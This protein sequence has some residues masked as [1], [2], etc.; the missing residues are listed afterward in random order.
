MEITIGTRQES[1]LDDVYTAFGNRERMV[2]SLKDRRAEEPSVRD[3]R[4]QSD[5]VTI[6]ST[7]MDRYKEFQD[8]K[9]DLTMS[10][11]A[12]PG[13]GVGSAGAAGSAGAPGSEGAAGPGHAGSADAS[14]ADEIKKQMEEA[15]KR[16]TQAQEKLN[17]AMATAEGAESEEQKAQAEAT[18]QAARQEVSAAQAEIEQLSAQLLKATEAA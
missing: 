11:L 1:R 17:S 10:P 6:S 12:S 14:S 13:D 15:Q 18:V 9:R 2:E 3:L 5:T 8:I 7:A 16:L 4:P